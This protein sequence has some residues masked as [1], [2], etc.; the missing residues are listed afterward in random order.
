MREIKMTKMYC[1]VCKCKTTHVPKRNFFRNFIE[2]NLMVLTKGMSLMY[3][4]KSEIYECIRCGNRIE[5][6]RKDTNGRG[7]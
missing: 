7:Y 5:I 6:E 2:G 3:N 1:D 4:Q